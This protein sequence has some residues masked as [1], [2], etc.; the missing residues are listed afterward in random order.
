MI[1]PSATGW[2]LEQ[3]AV[4]G[5]RQA[6]LEVCQQARGGGVAGSLGHESCAKDDLA[7]GVKAAGG[8]GVTRLL[9]SR[10]RLDLGGGLRAPAW[11]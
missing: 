7:A 2:R 6:G 10:L 1:A 4:S 3:L 9:Q 8:G 11:R 5:A